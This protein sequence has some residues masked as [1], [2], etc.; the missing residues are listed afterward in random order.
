[1]ISETNRKRRR[2][3]R[4]RRAM[5]RPQPIHRIPLPVPDVPQAPSLRKI[6]KSFP[7]NIGQPKRDNHGVKPK[8]FSYPELSTL[9]D[10][11]I[12][13][14][15]EYLYHHRRQ[16][17]EMRHMNPHLGSNSQPH[18]YD[19]YS[20]VPGSFGAR[21]QPPPHIPPFQHPVPPPLPPSQLP[22]TS[23]AP[24]AFNGPN[25]TRVHQQHTQP[26]KHPNHHHGPPQ[27][28]PEQQDIPGAGPGPSQVTPHPYFGAQ[29]NGN[30]VSYV[31]QQHH[32]QHQQHQQQHYPGRRSAS[33]GNPVPNGS[34]G[35]PNGSWSS[36][37]MGMSNFSANPKPTNNWM[38]ESRR[39]EINMM[40]EEERERLARERDKREREH[41]EHERQRESYHMQQHPP[42]QPQ[43]RHPPSG[44]HH[45]IHAVPL[46]Q[47]QHHHIGPPHHHHHRHVH[48]V[49]HHHGQ[50]S[51]GGSHMP[52]SLSGG[53][54]LAPMHNSH[55]PREFDNNRPHSSHNQH[56][57][58]V[59]NLSSSKS[60]PPHWKG[61]EH[62]P[63][64]PDHSNRDRGK[65][66]R[67]PPHGP[68]P[69]EDRPLAMPFVMTSTHN[70]ASSS[71]ISPPSHTP[72]GPGILSPRAAWNP[73]D[74]AAGFRL[75][76]PSS[77]SSA[78]YH[79]PHDNHAHSPGHRYTPTN[80]L[81][82][83]PPPSKP[84]HQ[85]TIGH[86]PPHLRQLPPSPSS[87]S[88][89]PNPHP[90]RSPTRF[91]P[92][93][94]LSTA[95]PNRSPPISLKMNRPTSPPSLSTKM[96][97]GPL[98]HGPPP[99][100]VYSPRLTGPGRTSTPTGPPAPTGEMAKNG[101]GG[102]P[103]GYGIGSR[104]ASPLMP[105]PSPSTHQGMPGPLLVRPPFGQANGE[106]ERERERGGKEKGKGRGREKGREKES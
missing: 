75:P 66:P 55:P 17:Y 65:P 25:P 27:Y 19:P 35:K 79:G 3:E 78:P 45:H 43:H 72:N 52:S 18:P 62:H 69:M 51:S 42:H 81:V 95:P 56:P 34:S 15:L 77:S 16:A 80:H 83:N 44:P 100:S 22:Q 89:Y 1:M 37:G 41:Q 59:I 38:G 76:T 49:H 84:S 2:M 7:I 101:N 8:P 48:V 96:L 57:T 64:P 13:H 29:G 88:L 33:P 90:L 39:S 6:V 67:A 10:G 50:P 97:N 32:Q 24:P 12:T 26:P 74:D 61:D 73:P 47:V 58:E 99:P 9:A 23:G 105:F 87:S 91:A 40:E 102:A 94:P 31:G 4:E 46:A 20:S 82:R 63:P 85:K 36:N 11:D 30:Q 53:Q 54:P 98:P 21:M 104:T 103:V 93:P 68:P 5:E 86:S 60:I 106:R 70:M 14:D 28:P 92:P 71:S